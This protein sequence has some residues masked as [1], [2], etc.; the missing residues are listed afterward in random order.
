ML[1]LYLCTNSKRM[2]YTKKPSLQYP[3]YIDTHKRKKKKRS[4]IRRKEGKKRNISYHT[5]L[6]SCNLSPSS[7]AQKQQHNN[8]NFMQFF[9]SIDAAQIKKMMLFLLLKIELSEKTTHKRIIITN[10]AHQ[11]KEH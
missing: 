1:S 3:I 7:E 6:P 5:L 10:A 9:F 2:H 11:F 8:K 4:I